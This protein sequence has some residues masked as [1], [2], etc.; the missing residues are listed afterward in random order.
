MFSHFLLKVLEFTRLRISCNLSQDDR[1]SETGQI[2]E[3]R[4]STLSAHACFLIKNL[5]QRDEHVRD[6][7]VNLLNRLK[8]RY[9][10]V[11]IPFVVYISNYSYFLSWNFLLLCCSVPNS[12]P[13]MVYVLSDSVELFLSGFAAIFCTE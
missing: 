8:D 6:I 10:Q 12:N 4:E 7:S 13:I 11:E 1:T 3:T 5:S 2:A 9:P